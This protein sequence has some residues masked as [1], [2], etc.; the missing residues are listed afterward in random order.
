MSLFLF[1]KQI[2]DVLYPYHWLDYLM[3]IMVIIA[4][5]YQ[6]LLV[7][8]D[9]KENA[10]LSDVIMVLFTVLLTLSFIKNRN[11]YGIYVKVLSAFLMYFVGRIY[12]E[13]IKECSGALVTASYIIVYINFFYRLYCFGADFL[14]VSNAEGDLYYY[15]TDMAFAM[16]LALCFIG[17]FGRNTL[18]KYITIFLVCPYMVLFSDA[19]IQKMLLVVIV[20]LMLLYLIEKVTGK[21]RIIN[22]ALLVVVL[23]LLSFIVILMFPVITGK[24]D[25]IFDIGVN[26]NVL[27]VKNMYTR[28]ENWREVW[29]IFQNTGVTEKLFGVDLA[30]HVSSLY[31]K[32]IYS[33]GIVGF[34]LLFI[35]VIS[36]AYYVVKIED[37]KT[38]YITVLL[39]VMLLGT[40]V[41]VSSMEATQMSW[42]P[43]MFSGMVVSGHKSGR[44]RGSNG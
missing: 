32:T 28:Y 22:A 34:V 16:I 11:A 25:V 5:I 41:T 43:L 1:L 23:G 31:L 29:L 33:V 40:G 26:D 21:R 4:L 14:K 27:N 13:R 36:V 10:A 35:F 15:D 6:I 2:V 30:A 7:R 37:R 12:Y 8:P 18:R 19:G 3:V 17:M 20:F 44:M 24:T 9:I 39:A 42:F 38:F